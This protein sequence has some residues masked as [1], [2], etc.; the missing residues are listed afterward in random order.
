MKNVLILVF[1]LFISSLSWA[2]KAKDNQLTK[3][4]KKEGYMLLFN[5][6]DLKG[7]RNFNKQTTNPQ[8]VVSDNAIHLGDKKGGDIVFDQDFENFELLID[9]K[10]AEAGNS[11][12]FYKVVEGED[13]KAIW[14]AAPEMQV[15]DNAKHSDNK[16]ITHTAGSLYDFIA[17]PKDVTH[18]VGEYNQAKLVVNKG[19]VEHWLNGE[20][21]L[22]VDI[23]SPEWAS[24]FEKSKFSKFPQFA[25]AKSGKIALQDHNDKVWFKNIKVK[26][27]N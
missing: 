5:G 6:K 13:V 4:E 15:L 23:N 20:K 9:W 26:P 22:E 12:I 1:A 17:P 8:W 3:A 10:I 25:Q 24:L 19:K 11:G 27:L 16:I 7:W 14:H 2:Q 18:P 21:L